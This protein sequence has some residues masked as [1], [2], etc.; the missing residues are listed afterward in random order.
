M[1][2]YTACWKVGFLGRY[3]E[4]W[5]QLDDDKSGTVGFREFDPEIA[6]S[7]ENYK[8]ALRNSAQGSLINGQYR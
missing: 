2:F 3:K 5:A 8:L 4:I 7:L 6:D 1:C